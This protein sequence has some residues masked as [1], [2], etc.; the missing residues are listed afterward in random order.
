MVLSRIAAPV[1]QGWIVAGRPPGATGLLLGGDG[2]V[3]V[4]AAEIAGDV[5]QIMGRA[6]GRLGRIP[7]AGRGR[8]L[9]YS[10]LPVG[11]AQNPV[12]AA[13]PADRHLC[14]YWSDSGGAAGRDGAHHT[15]RAGWAVRR[16][17]GDFRNSCA[18]EKPGG[19]QRR[20][21]QRTCGAFGAGSESGRGIAGRI[22]QARSRLEPAAG[23]CVVRRQAAAALQ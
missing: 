3:A 7:Y 19:S 5:C 23:V 9:F 14:L 16:V 17:R 20:G 13:E 2:R 21:E 1:D 11:E 10:R 12:A 18:A 22:A 6:S 15:L 8:A 4:R